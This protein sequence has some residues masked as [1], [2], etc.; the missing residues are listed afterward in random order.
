V[1]FKKQKLECD[2]YSFF[3]K[4]KLTAKKQD[5]KVVCWVVVHLNLTRA[6][7][8]L[9]TLKLYDIGQQLK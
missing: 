6:N 8:E 2:Q 7:S 1:Y 5:D 3:T 9:P 4:A